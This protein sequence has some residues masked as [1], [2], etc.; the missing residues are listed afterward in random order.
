MRRAATLAA[1]L[2][3]GIS[4]H[5]QSELLDKF[6]DPPRECRPRVWWHWMNGN[7]SHEG[8]RKDIEWMNAVGLA[9]FHIFDAGFDVPTIVEKRMPFMTE[10]WK[11]E[12][13]YALDL[14]DSL[15]F[16]VSVASSPGWS[17]TGGP[18][19]TRDDAMKKLVWSE[20]V[21]KGGRHF[22]GELQEPPQIAGFYQTLPQYKNDPHRYDYYKDVAVVAVKMLPED[23]SMEE[24]GAKFSTSD[25]APAECLADGMMGNTLVTEPG[26]DGFA[27]VQIAFDKPRTIKAY[28]ESVDNA[29]K[30]NQ[31]RRL[32]CSD[33]GV[34]FRTIVPR[35]PEA[36]TL[37]NMFDIAPTT[38]QYFRF[39]SNIPGQPLMYAELC[40]FTV[41]K[42]NAA[43][44]KAGF[45]T[46]YSLRDFYPTPAG[47]DAVSEVVDLS[48]K[49]RNGVLNWNVPAGRWKIYRFGYSLTGKHNGPA[50]P[51]A[52][53]LE[54][55]K[56]NPEAVQRYYRNYLK[57]YDEASGG[58]LGTVISHIMI[59]SY[60]ARCQNWT[61]A[62]P[63]EFEAR[64][65][66]SLLPW[67]PAL[68][69]QVIG[70]AER[71]ERF[72]YDWRRTLEELM[73]EGHYDSVDPVLA[74]YGLKRHTEAQE[75]SRVYNADGMDVRRN[76]DIPMA[77]FWMREFYSS[78]PCEEADMRE[79][80]SVAHI[81]GQNIVAAESFTTNGN[82]PDGFG[83]RRAWTQHPGSLKSGADAAMASGL[84]RFIIHS[85]VHQPVDDKFPGLTLN[86]YG[87]AFN[88]HNTW[89]A[90]ARPW[91]D[92]LARST[93]LLGQGQFAADVAVY[94]SETTNAVARFK[95]ERPLVPA[96]HAYDFI[97]KTLVTGVLKAED[98]CVAAPSGM[99]Y[100]IVVI[101]R[102]VTLMSLPV[103][104]KFAEFARAGVIL[105]G[106]EPR[107]WCDL[108]G[109]GDEFRTLVDDIWHSGRLNVLSASQMEE[110]LES[111]CMPRDV[112]FLNPTG[113]DIRF[114]HRHLDGGAELYWIANINPECRRL[115]VSFNVCGRK[116]LILHPDSGKIEEASYKM[117]DGRTTVTLDLVPDDAQFVLFDEKTDAVS[118][119][120][121]VRRADGEKAV[122]GPWTVRF[123][124]GRG[125]PESATFP[126]LVLLNESSC[127]GIR[128]FSGTACY[129]KSFDFSPE[130]G[131]GYVLDLGEVHDMARVLVNGKDL[132]L[133][134]KE[135][136]KVDVTEALVEGANKLEI[137]V[138]NSWH[139]RVI[140]DLQP[141]AEEQVTYT[142]YKF[143]EADSALR[144]A[145]MAGPVKMI[146]FEP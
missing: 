117:A 137:L 107:T 43:T 135:P 36:P 20:T 142:A 16:E 146:I 114:V 37:V 39:A 42:V 83:R 106:D 23:L 8:V 12:F 130:K 47:A 75:Y 1:A 53:G 102:E 21:V 129:E 134:W 90:E 96:G 113:A 11:R 144:E 26:P 73:A 60:E 125:A 41:S 111:M 28:L 13:N 71:T 15:G 76:A 89:A 78:Y 64:R 138:T 7:V 19:V 82:D 3:L 32:E 118:C 84:T 50:T 98:G 14:A 127:S 22:R 101:D 5:A 68:A 133:L 57:M 51:E 25:G 18:W 81:Y 74:E 55:D 10:G 9:G 30:N 123:Q 56:L 97:N 65:G 24:M 87:M 139:N 35:D 31:A 122:D 104:R 67:L 140:G 100:R 62:M 121:P 69:G 29:D 52:T 44:E 91:V 93:F 70:S 4:A 85:N 40:L 128:Y 143:Y 103:L 77:A 72:L 105:V 45:F 33:D 95:Y 88:R 116:P 131:A 27:W 99:R 63:A 126:K 145:G 119:E 58:R 17:V 132:G 120:I 54:V 61:P 79:A 124:E 34:H 6:A 110:A 92:Y 48:G 141:D 66:Y 49:Y 86:N 46:S 112:D 59:D 136:F 94:Y 80:A 109:D 115:D 38:A 2:L 108:K